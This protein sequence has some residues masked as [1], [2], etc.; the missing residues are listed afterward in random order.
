MR[1]RPATL[2]ALLPIVA[3]AC[4]LTVPE[5][6]F[7]KTPE[8]RV[9]VYYFHRTVRCPTC[10]TIGAYTE[11]AIRNGF[12]K[13]RRSGRVAIFMIDLQDDANAAFTKAY[14]IEGP[15]LVISDVQGRRVMLW[16]S[17]PKIWSLFKKKDAFIEYVQDEVTAYLE[18]K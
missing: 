18:D 12:R 8:H 1:F 14:D 2:S 5:K 6:A 3:T 7:G 11:E 4:M 16:K 13:E 15:T 9:E 17:L 10:K